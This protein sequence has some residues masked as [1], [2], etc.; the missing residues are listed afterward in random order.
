MI[1][2]STAAKR[3]AE[4]VANIGDEDLG[5]P[6]PCPDYTVGDLLDHV[7]G[8]SLA[9]TEAAEK[10]FAP[11][12]SGSPPPGDAAH[13]ADGWRER[14]PRQLGTLAEAWSDRDAWTGMTRAGG[15]EMPG[16]AAGTVAL[17]EVVI[18]GWD[19][20]RA[21]GQPFE[22]ADADLDVVFGWFDSFPD[23]ARGDAFAHPPAVS[24][25]AA[26]L[27]RAVAQSGRNPQW[28]PPEDHG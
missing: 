20:A 2:L 28:S 13:L 4:V 6:T 22:V 24:E 15:I 17:E 1:D 18:H 3:M 16:E 14:I 19:L 23:E 7:D 11:D 5:R 10:S 27:E 8:L 9:F 12:V 21:T 25:S 26:P